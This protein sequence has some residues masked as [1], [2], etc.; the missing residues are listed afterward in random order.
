MSTP[1]TASNAGNRFERKQWRQEFRQKLL[2]KGSFALAGA[3]VYRSLPT[4]LTDLSPCSPAPSG[5]T[6]HKIRVSHQSGRVFSITAS[7]E[8]A[9]FGVDFDHVTD[10]D[11][12]SHLKLM[13]RVFQHGSFGNFS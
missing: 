3:S 6:P 1:I 9:G 10:F 7:S 2:L 8:F 4:E 11:E 13:L 12:L 5:G